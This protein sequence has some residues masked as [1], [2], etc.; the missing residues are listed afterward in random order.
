MGAWLRLKPTVDP[1]RFGPQARV[2][3]RALQQHGAIV[4]DNGSSW[5]ISG[6]PD[7]RWDNDDLHGLGA[8]HG[9]DFE[10]VDPSSMVTD[11][12]SG[13]VATAPARR[14]VAGGVTVDGF[15]GLHRFRVGAGPRSARSAGGPYWRG[16]GHRP[17]RRD[18]ARPLGRVRAR[19]L[20][21]AA[22][23]RDR[24][25]AAAAGGLGRCRTGPAGT[26]PAG[27][28]SCPTARVATCVDGFG[29]LH[30]FRIGR[31]PRRPTRHAGAVLGRPRRRRAASR[32]RPDGRSGLRGGRD[33]RAVAR[34]R[35]A[36]RPVRRRRVVRSDRPRRV[37]RG[38][39]LLPDGTARLHGRRPRWAASVRGRPDRP[40]R[41]ARP[42]GAASWTWSIARGVGL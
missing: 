17:R 18:A 20:R 37:M 9:S 34:S 2:V 30:P 6:A 5:Y 24:H 21:R 36:A 4:A 31:G 42:R 41:A 14:D 33:R 13:R 8:L 40:G 22:P 19:R 35:S 1:A 7:D 16:L 12:N 39:T 28:R 15:G 38:V 27:W 23:V 32:S 26:S 29:G 3:V 25:R 10:F 11:P